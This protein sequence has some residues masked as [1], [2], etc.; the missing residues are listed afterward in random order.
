M[1]SG[2]AQGKAKPELRGGVGL[3]SSRGDGVV[4]NCSLDRGGEFN[5]E[6]T[7][8]IGVIRYKHGLWPDLFGLFGGGLPLVGGGGQGLR[9]QWWRR[10]EEPWP[11]GLWGLRGFRAA[12]V[13]V[14]RLAVG[15]PALVEERWR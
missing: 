9:W 15:R 13:L 12:R 4:P 6:I 3:V 10:W 8:D 2:G 11:L 1:S 14:V 5:D 7:V